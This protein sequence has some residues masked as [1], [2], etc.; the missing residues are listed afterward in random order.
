V[1]DA[2]QGNLQQWNLTIETQVSPTEIHATTVPCGI[3]LPDLQSSLFGGFA[4][5]GIRFPFALF[6]A[7]AIPHST[8]TMSVTSNGGQLGFTTDPFAILVGLTLDNAASAAWP[9]TAN[10]V[11]A[12]HDLDGQVGVTVIPASGSGYS[13]PPADLNGNAADFIYI[14]E[15]T[16]SALT[17]VLTSCNDST[18]TVNIA[19]IAGSSAIDSSV[20]GCH[21]VSGGNCTSDQS[22]FIDS[23]RPHFTP[24]GPG[25]MTSIRLPDGSTCHDVRAQFPQQ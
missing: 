21:L 8:F 4:K 22:S 10:I 17:G 19:T 24:N 1:L 9:G 5:Y 6:D 7:G 2:G 16:V 14:A 3:F 18:A 23:N 13:N 25:S 12:D 11:P 15:R 20:I